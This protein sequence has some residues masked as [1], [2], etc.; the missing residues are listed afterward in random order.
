MVSN[1][2]R[3]LSDPYGTYGPTTDNTRIGMP[4]GVAKHQDW[5]VAEEVIHQRSATQL[6]LDRRSLQTVQKRRCQATTI[7]SWSNCRQLGLLFVDIQN[8][9]TG[10]AA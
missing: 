7:R 3:E 2:S 6:L 8:L 4:F 10:A 9:P 1:L 5:Q